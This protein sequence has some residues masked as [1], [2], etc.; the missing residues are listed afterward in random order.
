MNM[1][2]M[3]CFPP[4]AT[5]SLTVS[6]HQISTTLQQSDPLSIGDD[7]MHLEIFFSK[8]TTTILQ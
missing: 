6:D 3:N 2:L 8:R 1:A 7:L 5:I 4:V